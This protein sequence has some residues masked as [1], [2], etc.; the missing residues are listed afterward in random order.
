M[1]DLKYG[2][3]NKRGDWAPF[4][5]LEVAPFWAWPPRIASV[6]HWL[7]EY[8]FP[9]NAFH[10]ATAL[11]YWR[12]VVPDV[13]TMKTLGWGWALWLYTVNAAASA[14]GNA[15]PHSPARIAAATNGCS[16][17]PHAPCSRGTSHP[18]S[19]LITTVSQRRRI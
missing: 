8:L 19:P 14:T 15:A 12:F 11:A 3:R 13:E 5:R 16:S 7:P 10:L 2:S 4:G 9:W 6:L 1:D 17:I 18:R